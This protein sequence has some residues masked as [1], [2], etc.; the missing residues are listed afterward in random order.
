MANRSNYLILML[1][2][3]IINVIFCYNL[4]AQPPNSFKYQA[5]L[6]DATGQ[7]L[8]NQTVQIGIAI[9]QGSDTGSEIFSEFHTVTTNS[10]GLVNLVVGSVNVQGMENI[11]WNI[12]PYFVQVSVDGTVIGTS[13]LLS[14][15]FAMHAFTVE[16]DAVDD[17][18]A[19]PENEIQDISISGNKLTI[20][21]GSTVILPDEVDDADADPENELQVLS[22]RNDTIFLSDGG[23]AILPS[24]NDPIFSAWDKSNGILISESQISDLNHFTTSDETDPFFNASLAKQITTSDTTRWA[25]DIDPNNELQLLSI[26]S[27]T[28]FL[29]N[30][31]FIKLPQGFDGDFYSLTNIP[32][33]LDTDA[34]DDF[35]GHYSS[36]SGAPENVSGFTNDAGYITSPDDADSDPTN[37][38]QF[39]SISNDTIYL[40]NSGFVK[41]PA[42]FD[43]NFNHL[44][45]IPPNLD[46]DA[47]DDFDGQYSS[48]SG[49]PQNISEFT[50]DVGY[51]T[52]PND[53]DANPTNELQ[54]ISLNGTDLSISQGS[55]VDLSVIQDGTGTD[56][57]TLNWQ[58]NSQGQMK[59]GIEDGN[60]VDMNFVKDATG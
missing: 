40:S 60:S 11:D 21:K 5:V 2:W 31:N 17:A 1:T 6:R 30:G 37:E 24:E 8:A 28:I 59:L 44:S 10:F 46:T 41:L 58:I 50:N 3:L 32:A 7:V 39:L 57:Q 45:N 29:S 49:V 19:D 47:T 25:Q 52:S 54:N 48:L 56:N 15:P 42:G 36:L 51:I 14:V 20:S 9:L 53:A 18:D 33:N 22:I 38:I 4:N 16:N 43:G 23:Y 12:G 13:Q 35:D 55:T 26:K 27:D 34:T